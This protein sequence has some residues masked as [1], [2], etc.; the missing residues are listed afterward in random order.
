MAGGINDFHK[1]HAIVYEELLPVSILNRWVISLD[2]IAAKSMITRER[3]TAQLPLNGNEQVL[4]SRCNCRYSPTK[5][6][7]VN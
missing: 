7:I 4:R 5:Q 3:T 6:F 1:T 2:R